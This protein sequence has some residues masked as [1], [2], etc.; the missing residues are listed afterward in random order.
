M[1]IFRKIE[2]LTEKTIHY[3]VTFSIILRSVKREIE[4]AQIFFFFD[5]KSW[6]S[7]PIF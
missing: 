2:V 7:R 1:D 3:D 5:W 6:N 4:E